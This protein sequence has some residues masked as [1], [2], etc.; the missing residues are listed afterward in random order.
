MDPIN[1]ADQA[2]EEDQTQEI[3]VQIGKA[4]LIIIKDLVVEIQTGH[5]VE[6]QEYRIKQFVQTADQNA[7]YPSN[8]QEIDQY[9][10]EIALQ[11]TNHQVGIKNGT[12]DL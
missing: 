8:Q 12:N 1:E 3:Q 11:K 4:D 6:V 7:I 10:A 5:L 2:H 9:I